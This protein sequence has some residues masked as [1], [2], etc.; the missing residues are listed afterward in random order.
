VAGV[1]IR[2]N[3]DEALGQIRSEVDAGLRQSG[4]TL[5]R[6]FSAVTSVPGHGTPSSPGEPPRLQS[7]DLSKSFAA[8]VRNGTLTV[9]TSSPYAGYLIAGTPNMLPR[10][11]VAPAVR[12]ATA[13]VPPAPP[14]PPKAGFFGAARRLAAAFIGAIRLG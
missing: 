1:L 8:D 7:G 11:F 5:V 13:S 3:G 6:A 14:A 2:W 9:T 10:P 4:E 12:L